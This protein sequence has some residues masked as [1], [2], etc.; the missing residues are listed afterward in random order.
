MLCSLE[1]GD[2]R[3]T[4]CQVEVSLNVSKGAR[5]NWK[6]TAGAGVGSTRVGSGRRWPVCAHAWSRDQR[7]VST[8]QD[9]WD[10]ELWEVLHP[11]SRTT[12]CSGSRWWAGWDWAVQ[13]LLVAPAATQVGQLAC[14][15]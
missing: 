4:F 3:P 7:T 6:G 8:C 15:G 11:N 14:P 1:A 2:P 10:W 9:S 13:G 5:F 12:A